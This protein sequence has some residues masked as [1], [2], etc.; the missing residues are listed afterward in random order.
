MT[1]EPIRIYLMALWVALMLS[2][3]LGDVLRIYSGDFTPGYIEGVKMTQLQW[4]LISIMMSL[5]ILMLLLTLILP[6]PAAR[7]V[8]I[9]MA[10]CWFLFNLAGLPTYPMIFDRYLNVFGLV[11]NIVTIWFAWKWV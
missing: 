3:L 6:P 11:I 8:N 2:Y 7:T 1:I 10:A 5:P 9:I 4:L